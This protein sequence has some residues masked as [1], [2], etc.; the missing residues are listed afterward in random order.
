MKAR[1]CQTGQ[2]IGFV[3]TIRTLFLISGSLCVRFLEATGSRWMKF[4]PD[5]ESLGFDSAGQ[6]SKGMALPNLLPAP[7]EFKPWNPKGPGL[8]SSA[9]LGLPWAKTLA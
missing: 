9:A 6:S 7:V 2:W 4:A 5:Q 3:H 8:A 1:Y